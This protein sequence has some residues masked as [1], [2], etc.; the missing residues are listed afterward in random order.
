MKQKIIASFCIALVVIGGILMYFKN[1]HLYAKK[2]IKAVNEN[3]LNK[4]ESLLEK[5]GHINAIPYNKV[6]AFFSENVNEPALHYACRKDNLEAVKLLVKKGADVNL[7]CNRYTPL[8]LILTFGYKNKFE[9][10]DYLLENN[11]DPKYALKYNNYTAAYYM[12]EGRANDTTYLKEE[13]DLFLKLVSLDAIPKADETS[14]YGNY[15]HYAAQRNHAE[16]M[17]YLIVN[18]NYDINSIGRDGLTPLMYAT[19]S[20]AYYAVEYLKQNNADTTIKDTH[21]KTA[22]DYAIEK[23]NQEIIDLLID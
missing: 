14:Y 10:V 20:N 2:L 15:L 19:Q 17:D 8:T 7:Y 3:D 11:A 16:I 18:M 23:A 1:D 12:M 4:L 6:G 21:H 9:I 22:L 5:G 13:Y